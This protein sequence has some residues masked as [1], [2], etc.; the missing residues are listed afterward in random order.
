MIQGYCALT[1]HRIL[2]DDFDEEELGKELETLIRGGCKG[3][4]CGMAEGFD[5]LCLR[6]LF[7]LKERYSFSIEA[8][9]PFAGQENYY[10]KENK[11]LYRKL[12]EKCDRTTTLEQGY[13][14]GCFLIRDRYMVDRAD[15]VFT[16]CTKTT[17]GTAYTV[18]YAKKKDK[19]VVHVFSEIFR[20]IS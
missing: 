2:P 14:N 7:G 8:C 1:G 11:L 17:G 18:N 20:L 6:L 3:F 15:F 9:V 16:Y 10:S 12:I 4:F 5:L 13:R 19:L